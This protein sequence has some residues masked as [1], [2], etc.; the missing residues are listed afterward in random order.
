MKLEIFSRIFEKRLQYEIRK[1][2][3]SGSRVFQ[4]GRTD[5]QTDK[6]IDRQT[7][8]LTDE[9][10]DKLI[11]RQTNRQTDKQTNKQTDR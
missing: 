11:D 2:P 9:Q 6:Q 7:D 5:R 10:T 1:I 3:S 4:C 8:R